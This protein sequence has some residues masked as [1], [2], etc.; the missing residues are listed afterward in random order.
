MIK[1]FH[2]SI[3]MLLILSLFVAMFS[4]CTSNTDV[5]DPTK[6]PDQTN[7]PSTDDEQK[8]KITLTVLETSKPAIDSLIGGDFNKRPWSIEL[9]KRT[10]VHIEYLM[11]TDEDY[12]TQMSLLITSGDI[13][14]IFNLPSNYPGGIERA[15]QEGL[16]VKIS[17]YWDE[18]APN[19]KKWIMS[20]PEWEKNIKNDNGDV[21]QFAA[22]REDILNRVFFGPMLRKDL[23]DKANLPLPETVDDWHT[24]L[25][26]FKDMGV[27]NPFTALNWFIGYSGAFA[28]AYGVNSVMYL[29]DTGIHYGPIEQGYKE[30]LTTFNQWY[31]EGLIDPDFV[32]LKDWGILTTKVTSGDSASLVHF[33]GNI[34]NYTVA[35][36]EV[37]PEYQLVATKYPVLNKGDKPK[38]GQQ[39]PPLTTTSMVS[40]SSEHFERAIEYLDYGYT[41]EGIALLNFGIEGESFNYDE[42]GKPVYSELIIPGP[43]T[44]NDWTQEQALAMYC[45]NA[46]TADTVD[47]KAYFEQIRLGNPLQLEAA[48]MWADVQFSSLLPNLAFTEEETDVTKKMADVET[49]VE[50]MTAKFILGDEPLDRFDEYVQTIKDWDIDEILKV[51]NDA[52]TRFSNR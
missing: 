14:D 28:G 18:H 37:T 23:L 11:T 10:G 24:T 9:E 43:N 6:K 4:G 39:D 17:D 25:T 47:T 44:K 50:E 29:D 2:A 32:T 13:P 46:A 26:A 38:F 30:Y 40:A 15:A 19:Y 16:M 42:S 49:Y 5:P 21:Y 12:D 22:L 35:G 33:L 45:P 36:K 48:K 20:N 27:K 7:E 52:Y 8:E 3:V 31:K 51:Y 1:R 41:D 34:V